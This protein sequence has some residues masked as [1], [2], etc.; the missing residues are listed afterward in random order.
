MLIDNEGAAWRLSGSENA[1]RRNKLMNKVVMI[2]GAGDAV[3]IR[4]V[5]RFLKK[6]YT[7][8]AA[9]FE[10]QDAQLPRRG[11]FRGD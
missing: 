6:E 9:L 3:G 10:G 8:A 11:V 4:L 7:V 2:A 5:K 1:E